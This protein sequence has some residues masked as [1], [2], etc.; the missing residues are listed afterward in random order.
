M[1]AELVAEA[2]NEGKK[3]FEKNKA[4]MVQEREK[5]RAAAKEA[6]NVVESKSE[7]KPAAKAAPKKEKR[8][9]AK[10]ESI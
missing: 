7:V 4:A 8:A 5:E 10:E 9:L 6:Q 3:D 2:I 1:M